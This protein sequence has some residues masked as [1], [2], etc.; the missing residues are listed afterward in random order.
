MASAT[1]GRQAARDPWALWKAG[2]HRPGAPRCL[3][4]RGIDPPRD[5]LTQ[6]VDLLAIGDGA[7]LCQDSAARP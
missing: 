5:D 6:A 7:T 1:D 2:L 3:S 4:R